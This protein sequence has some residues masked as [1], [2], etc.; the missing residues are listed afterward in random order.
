MRLNSLKCGTTQFFRNALRNER[1][2]LLAVLPLLCSLSPWMGAQS[3][4]AQIPAQE[5]TEQRVEHLTAAVA[6]AQAQVEAY[7]AQL[8]ELRLQLAVLRQQM[9]AEKSIGPSGAETASTKAG[10]TDVT[11]AAPATL[12]E[13]R[14]RQAI[15]ESQI[16]THDVTKVETE[17][18]YPLK[19][20]GLVLFNA[21]V[22]TRQVDVSAA[23]SYALSGSGSTGL[24][25]DQPRRS[26]HGLFCDRHSFELCSQRCFAVAYCACRIGL[27]KHGSVR[28]SGSQHS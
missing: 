18:K 21:F 25:S 8:T 11:P 3:V 7:Q 4:S 6:Q 24:R 10:V 22:N 13:I 2:A 20:S 23:P 28:R 16:A 5:S 19:V 14:E 15:E 27:A 1:L 9:T 17:S 12:E 26:S